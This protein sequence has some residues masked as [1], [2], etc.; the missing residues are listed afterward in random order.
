LMKVLVASDLHGN[1]HYASR[2][3]ETALEDEAELI[4][5][6]GDITNFGTVDLAL[7]VLEEISEAGVPIL[8]VP[9]NCDPKE[10]AV[11][12]TGKGISCLHNKNIVINGYD[13]MGLG[14][15]STT[16]FHTLFELGEA[17][18]EAILEETYTNI[19]RTKHLILISHTPPRDT[20]IDRTHHGVAAGSSSVRKFISDKKP[21]VV[22]SGHIHESR[23]IDILGPT[24]MAN[25]GPAFRGY[26]AIAELGE[27]V[28]IELKSF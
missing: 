26:Y 28:E 20:M 3:G 18:I 5:I 27:K 17:E 2:L 7:K 16:P 1:T 4:T 24:T 12:H 21:L 15:S 11:T 9:G 6:C 23:G 8:F 25:P 13:F 10:L 19:D 22:F 14:G